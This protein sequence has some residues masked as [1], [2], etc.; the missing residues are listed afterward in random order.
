MSES[1][2]VMLC[3]DSSTMRRLIKTALKKEPRLQV[4]FEAKH[5]R[6]AVD[7]L[8]TA[9]PD[10]VVMDIEMPVMDGIDA[11]KAIRQRSATL[12]I[13]MFSSLTAKGA[14]ATLDALSAGANDFAMKPA[15]AGHIDIALRKL[16]SD[17]IPKLLQHVASASRKPGQ[18]SRSSSSTTAIGQRTTSPVPASP[19][20]AP[21]KIVAIGVSTGGPDALVKLLSGIPKSFPVPILITQHMPPVFTTLLAERLSSQSGHQV[22]EAKNGEL[23]KPGRVL[24]APGDFHMTVRKSGPQM[25]VHL[26]QDAKENACRPAVDPLF[27]SIAECYRKTA[28]AVV[29]TGMGSD[30]ALGSKAIKSNGGR[31][32]I[33]DEPTSVV[34]GMPG[35]VFS[36]GLADSVL[37]LSQ[38]A[39]ELVRS[40]TPA[41]A[42]A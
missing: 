7:N 4:I 42:F 2:R 6:E 8:A 28:T 3:D 40:V 21:S 36:T 22:V 10:V 17:L 19:T 30:G 13:V 5:G 25:V 32:V 29:L 16:Q 35:K 12:P 31:I 34:W 15:A 1:I 23:V 14:E 9:K 27:R 37:P 39:A 20:F 41:R 38:I 24:L 26:N 18:T 33:Q 11:T